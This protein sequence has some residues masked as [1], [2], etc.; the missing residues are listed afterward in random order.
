MKIRVISLNIGAGRLGKQF[1]SAPAA[2]SPIPPL[3]ALGGLCAHLEALAAPVASTVVGLQ[4]VDRCLN[5]TDGVDQAL[6]F[7]RN[8]GPGWSHRFQRVRPPEGTGRLEAYDGHEVPLAYRAYI[9]NCD[10]AGYGKAIL[11]NIPIIKEQEWLFAWD[12]QNTAEYGEGQA[13]ALAVK[14]D[15]SEHRF[16]FVNCHLSTNIVASERQVWQMLGRMGAL[17]PTTPILLVGDFNIRRDGFS[18]N[19]GIDE[20]HRAAY[21]RITCML[22]AAGFTQI[23]ETSG[24]SFKPWNE[25]SRIDFVFLFDPGKQQQTFSKIDFNLAIAGDAAEKKYFTDHKTL[26]VDLDFYEH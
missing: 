10:A 3:E 2:S 11:A 17:D 16:W 26:V 18:T 5:I 7:A 4:E 12:P 1:T 23:G 20:N 9:T 8:I 24:F 22:S 25:Y 13:G 21:R 15:T 14:L 19:H 6:F